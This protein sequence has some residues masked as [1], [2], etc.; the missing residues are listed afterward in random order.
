VD[1]DDNDDDEDEEEEAMN[2]VD[3]FF[4]LNTTVDVDLKLARFSAYLR[5]FF[6][7]LVEET[8]GT[9]SKSSSS[10]IVISMTQ[11]KNNG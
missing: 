3:S 11:T 7:D 6:N 8:A 4:S 10:L 2:V 1:D 5:L 9:G